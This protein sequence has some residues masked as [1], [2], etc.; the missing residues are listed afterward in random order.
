MCL[1]SIDKEFLTKDQVNER[2]F[3]I[4]K[5]PKILIPSKGNFR[6]VLNIL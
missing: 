6:Q 1:I 3:K 2:R 4:L 5:T